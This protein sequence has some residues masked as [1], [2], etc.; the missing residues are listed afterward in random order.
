MKLKKTYAYVSILLIAATF[1]GSAMLRGD[2]CSSSCTD[3]CDV[4]C[5]TDSCNTVSDCSKCCH[6]NTFFRPRSL[7][8]DAT[9]ELALNNY[10]YYYKCLP[11][12]DCCGPVFSLNITPFYYHS[13]R[14]SKN[15]EFFLPNCKQCISV[16][17]RGDADVNSL[18][19]C[20]VSPPFGNG[21]ATEDYNY[22]D[23]TFSIKPR[24]RVAG[25]AFNGR[26]DFHNI[27]DSSCLRDLWSSLYIPVVHVRHSLGI[28]EKLDGVQG[29]V[30]N[31]LAADVTQSL[32]DP[33]RDYA[34]YF[35]GSKSKA[36]VDDIL[37]KL[38]W[39]FHKCE[40]RH[41]GAY[42]ALFIPTGRRAKAEFVFE[43]TFG[44][45]KH[46]GVGAGLNG[47]MEVWC[48]ECDRTLTLMADVRYAYF[49]ENEEM[50]T[51]DL[52]A[53]GDW[54][55]YLLVVKPT[56]TSNP[57]YAAN[58][59]TQ[60]VDVTPRST[61]DI[62]AALHYQRCDWN[63]ELGYEFW[64]RQKEKVCLRS[65]EEPGVGIFDIIG[66]AC[67]TSGATTASMATI[68]EADFFSDPRMP[69]SDATYTAITRED[70]DLKSA[71]HPRALS[72]KVYLAGA[73][74]F[75]W[76]CDDNPGMVGLGVAYEAAHKRTALSYVSVWLKSGIRF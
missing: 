51:F 41:L 1:V 73:K 5:G 29:A 75:C 40:D 9:L 24:R 54:S 13:T 38:G 76:G 28:S 16:A 6:S 3:G 19:L 52:C 7:S 25:V 11:K 35:C 44:S 10:D 37:F 34:R 21:V 39:D 18:W 22:F 63:L 8:T 46:V 68:C 27:C 26:I 66:I 64:W 65:C 49:I 45:G 30:D 50:R 12:D 4:V 17:E 48:D 59:L 67:S 36:G 14:R 74:D 15:A 58:F 62:W 32:T 42:F 72:S 70:L 20:L 47:A 57:L 56:D 23:S 53:N 71:A 31:G 33:A 43:P 2:N 55:R 69:A 60:C 61:I